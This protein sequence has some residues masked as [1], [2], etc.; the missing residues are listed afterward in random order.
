MPLLQDSQDKDKTAPTMIDIL[1]KKSAWNRIANIRDDIHMAVT[2]ALVATGKEGNEP[3]SVAVLLTGDDEIREFNKRF[4][5]VDKPTNVLAFPAPEELVDMGEMRALGDVVLAYDTTSR[6][7]AG[8]A[9]DLSDHLTH[10]VIHGMLHL[11]GYDHLSDDEAEAMEALESRIMSA[12]GRP[13]PHM[14]R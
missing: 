2:A 13:D 8:Q 5:Q 4:R 3:V 1:V 14:D 11:L 9:I 6:E 10:L 7:A 12:L